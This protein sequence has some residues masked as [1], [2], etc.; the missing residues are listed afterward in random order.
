MQ[1]LVPTS[2]LEATGG[3]A[4][5]EATPGRFGEQAGSGAKP[6]RWGGSLFGRLVGSKPVAPPSPDAGTRVMYGSHAY[7]AQSGGQVSLEAG[8]AVD[9]CVGEVRASALQP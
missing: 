9:A 2:Y 1:G 5:A 3:V 7:H 6:A 4:S 8:E